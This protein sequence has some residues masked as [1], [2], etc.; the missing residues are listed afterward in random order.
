MSTDDT[1]T[2]PD[3]ETRPRLVARWRQFFRNL[4]QLTEDE[5]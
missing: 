5:T 3:T 4:R 2:E 1:P